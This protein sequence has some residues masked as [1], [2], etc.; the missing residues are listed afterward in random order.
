MYLT[1]IAGVTCGMSLPRPIFGSCT[2]ERNRSVG[3]RVDA[4]CA[5]RGDRLGDEIDRQ[6]VVVGALA[7]AV[8]VELV[9]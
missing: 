9:N 7:V 6:S 1:I 2:A 8:G 5:Q 4:L 3:E